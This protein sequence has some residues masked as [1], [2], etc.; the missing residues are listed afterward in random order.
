M[1]IHIHIRIHIIIIFYV[2]FYLYTKNRL[3]N[4]FFLVILLLEVAATAEDG[5]AATAAAALD[6][7]DLD[8]EWDNS[9]AELDTILMLLLLLL[10]KHDGGRAEGNLD[11]SD[12][13]RSIVFFDGDDDGIDDG[14]DTV[15]N[16]I[17]VVSKLTASLSSK[18]KSRVVSSSSSS[19]SKG[20]LCLAADVVV[21]MTMND[22]G[23]PLSSLPS[24][25]LF[26]PNSNSGLTGFNGLLGDDRWL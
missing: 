18:G 3:Q 20:R 13:D 4:L 19:S 12:E 5:A 26:K 9:V 1:Y 17:S 7:D 14:D 25:S 8:N 6:R 10:L 21:G 22:L 2:R 16:A 15:I 23:I 24:L 11:G